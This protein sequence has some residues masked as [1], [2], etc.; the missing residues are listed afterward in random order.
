MKLLRFY[1]E[2]GGEEFD[3]DGFALAADENDLDGAVSSISNN[4]KTLKRWGQDAHVTI[5]LA[6]AGQSAGSAGLRQWCSGLMECTADD[7]S[8][9]PSWM[10]E[11]AQLLDF[12]ERIRGKLPAVAQFCDGE[13]FMLLRLIY[14][15]SGVGLHYSE[16][17]MRSLAELNAGLSIDYTQTAGL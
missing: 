13:Y 5:S 16:T 11:E 10:T 17:L 8:G 14:A 4:S 15:G 3:A 12:I 2:V 6:G 1:F 9:L 7:S